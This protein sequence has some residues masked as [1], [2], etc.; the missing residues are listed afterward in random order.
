MIFKL[1]KV[2]KLRSGKRGDSRQTYVRSW[3]TPTKKIGWMLW[4][5]LYEAI[6]SE[7]LILLNLNWP[8]FSEL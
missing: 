3:R 1:A 2:E 8:F 6:A 7:G 4:G 5:R